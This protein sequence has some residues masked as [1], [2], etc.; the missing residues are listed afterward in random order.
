MRLDRIRVNPKFN[1]ADVSIREV[2]QRV[3]W[4][5][6][7]VSAL[8]WT[9]VSCVKRPGCQQPGSFQNHDDLPRGQPPTGCGSRVSQELRPFYPQSK[10]SIQAGA[11][12][13]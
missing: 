6:A 13:R 5:T 4:L 3:W 12:G 7:A 10:G 9:G 2:I 8:G 1:M 11:P